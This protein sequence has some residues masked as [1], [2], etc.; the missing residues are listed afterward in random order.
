MLFMIGAFC[1]F[2]ISYSWI[3]LSSCIAVLSEI[4]LAMLPLFLRDRDFMDMRVAIPLGGWGIRSYLIRFELVL[5]CAR[6]AAFIGNTFPLKSKVKSP[7]T[8]SFLP[9]LPALLPG[10]EFS[11]FSKAS[12]SEASLA[13][14]LKK[15]LL[16]LSMASRS[17]NL[18][19]T[20]V[21]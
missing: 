19:T 20:S 10:L 14:L 8:V 7:S 6:C 18:S 11:S 9:C 17:V 12:L 2:W 3:C 4:T 1:R 15:S 21:S 13:F 16:S 5:S